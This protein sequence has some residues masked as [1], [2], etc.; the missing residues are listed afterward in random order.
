MCIIAACG[1]NI[2]VETRETYWKNE[3]AQ[4]FVAEQ[5]IV[6]FREWVESASADAV[7]GSIDV[8]SDSEHQRYFGI[9]EDLGDDWVC[10]YKIEVIVSV[11]KSR[12]VLSHDVRSISSCL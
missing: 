7:F 9:L 5:D 8:P 12:K 3:A 4:F 2:D 10:R 6:A 1:P 11:D